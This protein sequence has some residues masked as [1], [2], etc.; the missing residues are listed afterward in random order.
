MPS[1]LGHYQNAATNRPYKF[2][3]ALRSFIDQSY[4]D[5]ELV[6]V[7]DGCTQT[8]QLYQEY[9]KSWDEWPH[10]QI[11]FLFI[12]KQ[13]LFSGKLRN[14]GIEYASGDIICYLDSDDL[15]FGNHL[16]QIVKG[17]KLMEPYREFD[18]TDWVFF[19]DYT[20]KDVQLNMRERQTRLSYGLIGTSCI[21][22]KRDLDIRWDDGYSHDWRLILQLA[23]RYPN[24]KKITAAG[25]L[26][27]HLPA[28]IDF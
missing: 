21:A 14:T 15:F 1:Y 10:E 13:E 9:K 12:K 18:K 6:I 26:V 11:A 3:R 23:D 8:M 20:A 24:H 19:N 5:K 2:Q 22:H 27:C 16:T 4:P 28:G 17:F 7:A 25:Y